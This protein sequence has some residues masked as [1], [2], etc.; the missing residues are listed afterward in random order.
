MSIIEIKEFKEYSFTK[1]D[2]FHSPSWTIFIHQVGR[3]SF[4]K[5]AKLPAGENLA[6]TEGVLVGVV[7]VEPGD[8]EGGVGVAGPATAVVQ[9]LVDA[10][11]AVLAGQTKGH[12]IVLTIGDI[13]EASD[14]VQGLHVKSPRC[15][16]TVDSQGVGH[17]CGRWSRSTRGGQ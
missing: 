16:Q 17:C 11:D 5:L 12:A 1:L 13:L 6:G 7:G 15:P 4:A 9:R 10:A 2:D 3:F 14:R 8:V